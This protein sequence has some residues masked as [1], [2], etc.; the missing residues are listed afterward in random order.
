MNTTAAI[1]DDVSNL[2]RVP[3]VGLREWALGTRP[4]VGAIA[5][6]SLMLLAC[7]WFAFNSGVFSPSH[8]VG[9]PAPVRIDDATPRRGATVRRPATPVARHA[10]VDVGA[11]TTHHRGAAIPTPEIRQNSESAP[12]TVAPV[13]VA[14]SP[15]SSGTEASSS[16]SPVAPTTAP[17]SSTAPP[18]TP[19]LD[20]LPVTLPVT[21]PDLSSVPAVSTVTTILG[22][23]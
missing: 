22:V 9:G 20:D 16:P 12:Q 1:T 4:V 21:P 11:R 10:R 18:T 23:P 7:S 15:V 8:D 3:S 14:R 19:T 2:D 6:S 13:P 17:T 5:A